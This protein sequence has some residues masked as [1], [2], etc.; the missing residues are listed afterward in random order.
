M[1][2][3]PKQ[4][5]IS[6][7]ILTPQSGGQG[8][9][10]TNSFQRKSSSE[11][12][13][14]FERRMT[15]WHH[16]S[17]SQF[18]LFRLHISQFLDQTDISIY[19]KKSKCR[20]TSILLNRQYCLLS[21]YISWKLIWQHS[22][23]PTTFDSEKLSFLFC[24][25]NWFCYQLTKS[26]CPKMYLLRWRVTRLNGGASDEVGWQ[27]RLCPACLSALFA[28]TTC[29]SQPKKPKERLSYRWVQ[30]ET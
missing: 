24:A 9:G 8:V 1:A 26:G 15:R 11:M 13:K 27:A 30:S 21:L 16:R 25:S 4:Y 23:S 17:T 18:C 28:K 29:N 22:K 14:T 10:H 12:L 20:K 7:D 5:I 3:H 2:F 6:A 19:S